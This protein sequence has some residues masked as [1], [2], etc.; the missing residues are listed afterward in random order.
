MVTKVVTSVDSTQT[1]Q[2]FNSAHGFW[3]F[4][5]EMNASK[6]SHSLDFL[7]LEGSKHG[8]LVYVQ[9]DHCC[10]AGQ[11]VGHALVLLVR[12]PG[13]EMMSNDD[14]QPSEVAF[15]D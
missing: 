8:G 14:S 15:L 1:T 10:K 5:C 3:S 2:H 4:A 7:P 11:W 12:L 6:H 13:L 9:P